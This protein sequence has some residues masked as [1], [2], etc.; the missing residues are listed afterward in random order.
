M[1]LHETMLSIYVSRYGVETYTSLIKAIV[2]KLM[3][4]K[5]PFTVDNDNLPNYCR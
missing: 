4:T 5:V 2:K 1:P 3:T